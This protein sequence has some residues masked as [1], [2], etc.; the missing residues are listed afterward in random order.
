M[1]NIHATASFD[2]D[3]GTGFLYCRQRQKD[4][5]PPQAGEDWVVPSQ[6]G[7]KVGSEESERED[8]A[9]LLITLSPLLGAIVFPRS[10]A[11]LSVVAGTCLRLRFG[12]RLRSITEKWPSKEGKGLGSVERW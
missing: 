3:Y 10:Y 8:A 4:S 5:S 7:R 9:Y 6:A 1:S 12:G 2:G 11:M